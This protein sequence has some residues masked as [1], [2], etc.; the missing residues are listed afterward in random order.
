MSTIKVLHVIARMNVGGTARYVGD[1][2]ENIPQSALATGYV[3][4]AE[5]EDPRVNDLPAYRIK[6]LGRKISPLNDFKA[7]LELRSLIR[8]LKPEIVHTHTFKAGLIGRLVGGSHERVHTFHGHLFGDKSFSSLE[9]LFITSIEKYLASRTDLLISVGER[10]GEELRTKGIGTRKKW[11]SIPPGV[12]PLSL[13]DRHEAR[14]SLGLNQE[15]LIVGWMARMTSVKNPHLMLEVARL[16][17]DVQFAMA[18][19]GDL[20][21]QVRAEAPLNVRVIG[22]VDSSV[23]WSAVDVAFS[24]SDNEGMPIA[25]IEAMLAELPVVATDVGSNSEIIE[26]EVN[27]FVTD[28]KVE[29]LTTAIRHLLADQSLLSKSIKS[30]IRTKIKEYSISRLVLK[31][32]F[33]YKTLQDE[34]F[35]KQRTTSS[36]F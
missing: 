5:I 26:N 29:A 30:N 6:H 13:I 11:I 16:L 21:E 32:E 12:H 10:V 8:E 19:G 1:L 9:K 31:H 22:W 27:G 24:T 15:G 36:N 18:G 28:N 3:Q 17:P 35:N 34:K 2:L 33:W 14:E 25:L 4:E 7:W 23:F 20:L